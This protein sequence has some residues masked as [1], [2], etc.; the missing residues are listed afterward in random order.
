LHFGGVSEYLEDFLARINTPVIT[1]TDI[2]FFNRLIFDIPE[3]FNFV[4]RTEALGS[5]KRAALY[6]GPDMATLSFHHPDS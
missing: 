2:M 1:H 5:V 3:L 4:S 6:L